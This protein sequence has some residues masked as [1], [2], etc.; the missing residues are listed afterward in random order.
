MAI[1]E[2]SRAYWLAPVLVLATA[3]VPSDR[4]D[5]VEM[6]KQVANQQQK[7]EAS[8][9]ATLASTYSDFPRNEKTGQYI[10]SIKTA[11]G[12]EIRAQANVVRYFLATGN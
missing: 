5:P 1:R 3:C 7:D 4:E 9:A 2:N 11:A 10:G 6:A 12:D 8:A